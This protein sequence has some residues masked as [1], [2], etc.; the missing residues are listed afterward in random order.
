MMKLII[1][2]SCRRDIASHVVPVLCANPHL[3]VVKVVLASGGS[4]DRMRTLQKKL[5]KTAQIG[6]LGALNGMRLRDWY[7][8]RQADDIEDV[9]R[10]YGVRIEETDFVNSDATRTLFH[11]AAAD[12]GLSLGNAYISESVYSIPRFGMMNIHMEILPDFQGAQSVIWPIHNAVRETGFT[13]HHIDRHIDN[14]NILYQERYPILLHSTLR[15]TV[16][17]TLLETRRRIPPAFSDVCEHYALY[18]SKAICQDKGK[19]YT[20]PTLRQFIRMLRVHR[21][22][23]RELCAS[24]VSS[25]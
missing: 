21:S 12:L 14:G 23:Y 22:M 17:K 19:G 15:E 11:E 13:I 18:A 25:A 2:T 24:S 7:Q 9:C 10:A 16:E 4:P 6:I 8:D 5:R 3:D 20:T 1:L